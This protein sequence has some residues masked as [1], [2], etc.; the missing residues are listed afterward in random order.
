MAF[1]TQSLGTVAYQI[2][3]LASQFLEAVDI[4]SG[5]LG[6]ISD[7]IEKLRMVIKLSDFHY[8][9]DMQRSPGKGFEK[10]YWILY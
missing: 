10:G 5:M 8:A 7:R 2:S 1:A 4:Q 3:R 6:E 9:L